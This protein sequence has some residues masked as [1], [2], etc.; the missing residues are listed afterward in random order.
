MGIIKGSEAAL[1][2]SSRY[3]GRTEYEKQSNRSLLGDNDDRSKIYTLFEA[4]QK[5][6]PSAAYDVADRFVNV[7]ILEPTA[8]THIRAANTLESML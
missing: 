3:L 2:K 1:S 4:Y 7:H 5:L 8:N 6:R